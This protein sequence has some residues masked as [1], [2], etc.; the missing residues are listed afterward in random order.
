[1]VQGG[2]LPPGPSEGG[3]RPTGDGPGLAD[4]KMKRFSARRKVEIVLRLLRGEVLELLSRE[5]GV[6]AARLSNWRGQFLRAGHAVLKKRPQDARD[7]EIARLQQKLGEVTM[8]NELLQKRSSTW[9][10]AVLYRGGGRGD[11]PGHLALHAQTVLLGPGIPG[12]A[13]GALYRLLAASP[14]GGPSRTERTRC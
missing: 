3:R 4:G 7:L 5:L 10:T 12:V 14:Q 8:A 13:P 1:M 6:T 2:G 9:R 11:E